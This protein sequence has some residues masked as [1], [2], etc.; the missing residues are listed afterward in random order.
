MRVILP[1]PRTPEP[2][3][4]SRTPDPGPGVRRSDRP[5]RAGP[6]TRRFPSSLHGE[7]RRFEPS[8]AH[9]KA[10]SQRAYHDYSTPPNHSSASVVTNAF[11]QAELGGLG[12]L[13]LLTRSS[14][15]PPRAT[16][17]SP[18]NRALRAPFRAPDQEASE[19]RRTVLR[20]WSKSPRSSGS[21]EILAAFPSES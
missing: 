21:T 8:S 20:T 3:T 7:G 9:L 6:L 12:Q 4:V 5:L 10:P 19:S 2:N 16:D 17:C 11:G 18:K 1:E 13:L 15:D 14:S